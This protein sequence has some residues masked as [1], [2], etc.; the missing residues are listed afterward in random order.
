[1][2]EAKDRPVRI[3]VFFLPPFSLRMEVNDVTV[4]E[5]EEEAGELKLGT[6]PLAGREKMSVVK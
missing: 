4:K 1:M 6:R 5:E 3:P 2:A